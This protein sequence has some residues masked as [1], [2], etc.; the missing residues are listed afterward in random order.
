[1]SFDWAEYLSLAEQLCSMPV[2][3]PPVGTEAQQRAGVS[4]AYYAAYTLARNRLRYVDGVHIP[5]QASSHLFVVAHYSNNTDPIRS[6]IG[7]ELT[8]LRRARNQCDYDD[9]VPGLAALAFLSLASAAQ[10]VADLAR[11]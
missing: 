5:Q 1:M 7:F 9:V 4:R 11:L 8:R 2:S 10:I 3:G 6:G